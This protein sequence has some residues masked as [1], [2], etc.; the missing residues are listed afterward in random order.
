VK[1]RSTH[2]GGRGAINVEWDSASATLT[3]RI[4]NRGAGKPNVIVG[5]LLDYMLARN[6]GRVRTITIFPD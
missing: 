1:L 6:K 2:P 3:C 5:D 4:V